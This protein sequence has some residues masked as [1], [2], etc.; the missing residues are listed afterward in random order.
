VTQVPWYINLCL[1]FLPLAIS[2]ISSLWLNLTLRRINRQEG[3][4]PWTIKKNFIMALLVSAPLAGIISL[5][6]QGQLE[7]YIYIENG[8]HMVMFDMIVAPF[9][10]LILQN[11][12]LYYFQRKKWTNAYN[13]IRVKHALPPEYYA[14][15]VS[16]FTIKHYHKKNNK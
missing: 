10:V 8:T 3:G 2:V 11:F 9:A 13:F 14:D 15:D 5:L 4:K 1:L 7:E 12:L 6:L 16:D